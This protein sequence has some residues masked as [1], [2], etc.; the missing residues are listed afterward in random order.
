MGNTESAY[1]CVQEDASDPTKVNKAWNVYDKTAGSHVPD[2]KLQMV[3]II[4]ENDKPETVSSVK[5]DIEMLTKSLDQM[6]V[7]LDDLADTIDHQ[8]SERELL[9]QQLD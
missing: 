1:A 4:D 3:P 9:T 2:K 8:E 7:C 6:R 5:K